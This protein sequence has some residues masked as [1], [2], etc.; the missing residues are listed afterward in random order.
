MLCPSARFS[1]EMC[2]R[3]WE[4]RWFILAVHGPQRKNLGF[5]ETSF[6]RIHKVEQLGRNHSKM[7]VHQFQST[8]K[9]LHC[10][11][12]WWWKQQAREKGHP[13]WMTTWSCIQDI[14]HGEGER[15]SS[16]ILKSKSTGAAAGSRKQLSI[17]WPV[18]LEQNTLAGREGEL[19]EKRPQVCH[20][21]CAEQE[22]RQDQKHSEFGGL[23]GIPGKPTS[24]YLQ[25]QGHCAGSGLLRQAAPPPSICPHPGEIRMQN[26]DWGLLQ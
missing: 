1:P 19:Q 15:R 17:S 12:L 7:K 8:G 16:Y 22:D 13:E 5:E 23:L 4:Q 24:A 11:W 14:L 18:L 6:S 20:C 25:D 10:L 21:W 3:Q 26:P 2:M 9:L